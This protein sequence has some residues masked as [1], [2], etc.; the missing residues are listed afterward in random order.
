MLL[1][2]DKVLLIFQMVFRLLITIE[3]VYKKVNGLVKI[4]QR[5][6]LSYRN[7]AD[8]YEPLKNNKDNDRNFASK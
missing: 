6:S 3:D 5:Q 7:T 2:V 8:G 1:P 4:Y